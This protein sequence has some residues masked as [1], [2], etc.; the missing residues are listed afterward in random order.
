MSFDVRLSPP[1]RPARRSYSVPVWLVN[2]AVAVAVG[3]WFGGFW[4]L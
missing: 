3:A 1:E 2:I 4:S